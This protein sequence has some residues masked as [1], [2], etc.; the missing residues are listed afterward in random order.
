MAREVTQRQL[1]NES[2]EIM[3]A[4]PR[5]VVR[6]H[7]QRSPVGELHPVKRRR[8]VEAAAVVAAF[9]G[10][11]VLDSERF[12]ADLDALLDQDPAPHV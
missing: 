7:A 3:R 10:A 5:R 12:R 11:P 2:G 1:R 9:A 8:F 4:R 6:R